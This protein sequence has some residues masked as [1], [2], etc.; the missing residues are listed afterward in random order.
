MGHRMGVR[1]RHAAGTIIETAA[2]YNLAAQVIG[3]V[4]EQQGGSRVTVSE[5]IGRMFTK[6][7]VCFKD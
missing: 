1:T 3:Y 6:N 2:R 4:Q 5:P 7:D